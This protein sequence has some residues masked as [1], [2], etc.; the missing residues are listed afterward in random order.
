MSFSEAARAAC[1]GLA[2]LLVAAC[3]SGKP[4]PETTYTA[5]D[6]QVKAIESDKESCKRLCNEDYARCADRGTTYQDSRPGDSKAL[7]GVDAT[8]RSELKD[9]LGHCKGR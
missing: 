4:Q 6:G 2:V 1:L 9:C 8:C 3:V 5:L 7:F